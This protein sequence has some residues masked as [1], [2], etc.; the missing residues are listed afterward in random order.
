MVSSYLFIYLTIILGYQ[1]SHRSGSHSAACCAN[2]KKRVPALNFSLN[3]MIDEDRLT[4][5]CREI[6]QYSSAGWEAASQ[7]LNLCQDLF[8]EAF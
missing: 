6:R 1:H 7:Y 3:K 2:R 5:L 4:G 8:L